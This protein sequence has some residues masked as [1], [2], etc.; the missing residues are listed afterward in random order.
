MGKF[1]QKNGKIPM[2]MGK[3]PFTA[4][5]VAFAQGCPSRGQ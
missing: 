5:H 4:E 3:F 2:K 1:P